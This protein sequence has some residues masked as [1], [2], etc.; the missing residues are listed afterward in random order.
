MKPHYTS[1]EEFDAALT[2]ASDAIT[3]GD[4]IELHMHP[5]TDP[6]IIE[7]M[8][9]CVPVVINKYCEPGRA[10]FVNQTKAKL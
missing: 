5:D 8:L 2:F 1:K 4:L 7:K 6:K 10:Y 9:A 3:A